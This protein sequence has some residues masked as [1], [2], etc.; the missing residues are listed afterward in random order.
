MTARLDNQASLPPSMNGFLSGHPDSSSSLSPILQQKHDRL[1]DFTNQIIHLQF[2]DISF[3]LV[4]TSNYKTPVVYQIQTPLELFPVK[5]HFGKITW[6]K[7]GNCSERNVSF[8]ITSLTKN[9]MFFC[10]CKTVK[11]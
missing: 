8:I 3:L 5:R 6:L 1:L 4:E 9:E 7:Y 2:Q 11:H 10:Y